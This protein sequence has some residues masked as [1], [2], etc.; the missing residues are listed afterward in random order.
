ML[1]AI[2]VAGLTYRIPDS[3]R[4]TQ[5][6]VLINRHIKETPLDLFLQTEPDKSY[7]VFFYT[8]S[9]PYCWNSL[10]NLIQFRNSA[11]VDSI[12]LYSLV[13]EVSSEDS[14]LRSEFIQN[15]GGLECQEIV[16]DDA[17]QAFITSVPTTFYVRNDTIRVVI[18]STLPHPHIF[19]RRLEF[20]R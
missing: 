6:D 17:V 14:A 18:K 12:V 8:Y 15:L 5:T 10:G 20:V 7:L 9:C 16:N 4:S 19:S 2:F 13:N 3:F 11:V 1:P